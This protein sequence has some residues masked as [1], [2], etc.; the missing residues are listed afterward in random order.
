MAHHGISIN[1][2]GIMNIGIADRH[3][4]NPILEGLV[5][6]NRRAQLK[7]LYEERRR[8]SSASHKSTQSSIDDNASIFSED[9]LQK[10]TKKSFRKALFSRRSSS[11]R[12]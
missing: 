7:V 11:E 5:P 6:E 10:P 3:I 8:G 4:V 2:Y 9:S 1:S 12:Q